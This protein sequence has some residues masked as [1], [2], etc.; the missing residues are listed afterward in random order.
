[1]VI[2][3]WV[4]CVADSAI[5]AT[6]GVGSGFPDFFQRSGAVNSGCASSSGITR[7]SLVSWSALPLGALVGVSGCQADSAQKKADGKGKATHQ[8]PSWPKAVPSVGSSAWPVPFSGRESSLALVGTWLFGTGADRIVWLRD[9][10]SG[11][12]VWRAPMGPAGGRNQPHYPQVIATGGR[13]L[14]GGGEGDPTGEVVALCAADGKRLW[15]RTLPGGQVSEIAISDDVVAATT[16]DF[17]FGL[18]VTTGGILWKTRIFQGR[19]II[20][21][22][23]LFI[24]HHGAGN[25]AAAGLDRKTGK[26]LWSER[27]KG[28]NALHVSASNGLVH[29]VGSLFA[30]QEQED[31]TSLFVGTQGVVRAISAS[32]GR[33]VWNRMLPPV[34]AISVL[35]T[36]NFLYLPCDGKL[37]ALRK[38]TGE[39]AWSVSL[40]DSPLSLL[41]QDELLISTFSPGLEGETYPA[42]A[43]DPQTGKEQWRVSGEKIPYG[44]RPGPQGVMLAGTEGPKLA[45]VDT[46]NG[47]TV[48]STPKRGS[49]QIAGEDL[50]YVYDWKNLVAYDVATGDVL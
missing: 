12:L 31:G 10:R 26:I 6:L 20:S 50:V 32:S 48:W 40:P 27:I 36:E 41:V 47:E 11:Q 4:N 43:L 21:H 44:V 42:F 49:V 8:C 35:A 37:I 39:T 34:E 19:E 28:V 23:G 15:A 2:H 46:A 5:L 30:V 17:V 13:V 45:A 7:R 24:L 3:D 33:P 18:S 9:A 29:V 38:D 14:F 22:G 16:S 25:E 1:M